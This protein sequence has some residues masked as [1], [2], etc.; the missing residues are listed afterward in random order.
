[1][2]STLRS[3]LHFVKEIQNVDTEGVEPLRGLRDET[4]RGEKEGAIGMEALK[5]ALETEEVVGKKH[6]RIRRRSAK[7][8]EGE[9][10]DALG[11]AARKVG[12]YFVVDG[13]KDG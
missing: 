10:W 13:G 7:N 6:R 4:A 1:M 3:Q 12:R 8:A 11:T 9:E 5:E 2:L